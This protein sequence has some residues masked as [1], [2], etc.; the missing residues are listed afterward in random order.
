MQKLHH[1]IAPL[2]LLS[3][4]P[5]IRSGSEYGITTL[6]LLPI[7]LLFAV[8]SCT[9]QTAAQQAI[10]YQWDARE[11][12][13]K[14]DL[15]ALTRLRFLT[16]TDFFPFNFIDEGGHL[17]GFHVDLSRA[18]CTAL[19]I[20]DRCQIQAVPFDELA[21]AL[22][23]GEGE[24]IVAGLAVTRQNRENFLFSRSYLQFPARFVTRKDADV[25]EPLTEWLAGKRVGVVEA[26]AHEE[27]LR[28]FFPGVEP[29]LLTN[30]AELIRSLAGSKL[31]AVFADGMRL[32]FHLADG[33]GH[34]CCAFAGGPYLA[35]EYLGQGL[36]IA[37]RRD[38]PVLAAAIDYALWSIETSGGFDELYLR[39]FPVGF[40]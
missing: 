17:A 32:G 36:A 20:L 8:L 1:F 38:T 3:V 13:A 27:M 7:I 39:Y 16:T 33:E 23:K 10:P 24:A 2:G 4:R 30:E 5:T 22:E 19:D 12:I 40:Y 31:D 35:P 21:S 18:I 29:V 14:P 37:V 25:R 6:R 28:D 11:R 34:A 26:T 15:S 9:G